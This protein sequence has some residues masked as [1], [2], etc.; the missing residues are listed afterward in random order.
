MDS[1]ETLFFTVRTCL[2]SAIASSGGT[3]E[4]Q[5]SA[6][7]QAS[8]PFVQFNSS[9]LSSKTFQPPVDCNQYVGWLAVPTPTLM[10]VHTYA[11][12]CIHVH[13]GTMLEKNGK[14]QDQRLSDSL[15][16]LKA[17]RLRSMYLDFH[18]A[19]CERCIK[20]KVKKHLFRIENLLSYCSFV[21][22][23]RKRNDFER[24]L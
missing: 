7:L 16:F 3:R 17:L 8:S 12:A 24:L 21:T 15:K 5:E 9:R 1:L 10:H 11:G 20:S 13:A 19:W 22:C 4:R 23:I 14:G 2:V 18:G 6:S